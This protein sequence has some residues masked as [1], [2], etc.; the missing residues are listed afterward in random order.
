MPAL[1][2]GV[3]ETFGWRTT[4]LHDKSLH[5]GSDNDMEGLGVLEEADLVVLYLRFRQWPQED[6][7][8][9]MR[10]VDGGGALVGFR[11]ST[12]A[13]RYEVGDPRIGFNDFGAEV[14][15]A[16]WIRHYGHGAS[17]DARVVGRGRD[18]G[19]LDGVVD[20]FHVRSWT[21]HVRPDYP[22]EDAR[23]LVTG[24]PVL[25]GREAG[26]ETVNPIAWTR[27]SPGGGRVFMTTM[28]H[29]EDFRVEAFRRLVGNGMHWAAGLAVPEVGLDDFPEVIHPDDLEADGPGDEPWLRMDY[30]PAIAT[31]VGIG[32]GVPPVSKGIALPLRSPEGEDTDLWAVFDTDLCAWRCAWRGELALRGIVYD[33]PHGTYPQIDGEILFQTP[34]VSGV[35]V[36]GDALGVFRDPR[37]EAWGPVPSE[38]CRWH[39]LHFDGRDVIFEYTGHGDRERVFERVWAEEQDGRWVFVREV[40]RKSV[41]AGSN[42]AE[43][44]FQVVVLGPQDPGL[45]RPEVTLVARGHGEFRGDLLA[46]FLPREERVLISI[47]GPDGAA[48]MPAKP[49]PRTLE[50]ALQS[51]RPRWGGPW[52]AEGLV[53]M[54]EDG[55]SGA[56]RF[57]ISGSQNGSTHT[58]TTAPAGTL[59]LMLE[60][61]SVEQGAASEAVILQRGAAPLVDPFESLKPFARRGLWLADRGNGT[62]ERNELSGEDDLRLDGVTWRRGVRGRSLD[63]DG[64]AAAWVEGQDL[65]FAEQDIT[66]AAWVHTTRDG[67]VFAMA[68]DATESWAPDGVTLFLREGRLAFDV[69]WVGVVTGGPDIRDGAWH[70]VAA[71]W[72]HRDG[73]VRLFL[74]GRYVQGGSLALE[75]HPGRRGFLPRWGWT[76][77]DFP[78]ES[79]FSGYMDG[80]A[81]LGQ[82]LDDELIDDLAAASGEEIVEATL[83]RWRGESDAVPTLRLRRSAEQDVVILGPHAVPT[84]AE[85]MGFSV[86]RQFGLRSVVLAWARNFESGPETRDAFRIDRLSWPGENPHGAWMRFGAMDLA[87]SANGRIESA[88]LTTWSG[89]LWRVDGLDE[90]L[91][92]L[93]WTRVATG[94][95]QPFGVLHRER[96]GGRTET[97][98]LGRDQITRVHDRNGDGEADFLEA[99]SNLNRNSEHF[100]EPASGLLEGPDGGLMYIKAARHAKHGLHSHHGTVQRV[101]ADGSRT[102]AIA[103]GFRAPIGLRLLPDGT[104]LGSDQEGHWTPANR[105]NLIRPSPDEPRFYGNGWAANPEAEP[106][107]SAPRIQRGGEAVHPAWPSSIQPEAPLCWIHPEVD[108]SPSSQVLA[109]H[110]AWGPLEGSIL[111]LSYGTGEV[112]LVLRDEFDGPNGRVTA[113]GGVV[114]LGI[115]LPTGLLD[116]M[117]HPTTGDLYVCGLFGWS[118][119]R[120]EPGG[121]YRVRPQWNGGATSL[122]VPHQVRAGETGLTLTF[123]EPLD[124]ESAHDIENWDA[125]AWNYRRS[126]DYGSATYTLDGGGQGR[127]QLEVTQVSVSPNPRIVHVTIADL[128]PCD[129]LDLHWSILDARGRALEHSAHLTLHA[130]RKTP[131]SGAP[132]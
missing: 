77:R 90:T 88:L 7:D 24:R 95:N 96:P 131:D 114:K 64:T 126:A 91:E 52:E 103:R 42:A 79:R 107:G 129:Q 87:P 62:H 98:V 17:T 35:S 18:D 74:D 85:G 89:D 130:Q 29:P 119:D 27:R 46:C 38:V 57:E 72:R 127:T 80:L 108:R 65:D 92:S 21:Y 45:V 132:R 40:T 70:H 31:A 43:P 97:L 10:Y 101:S 3:E 120:T 116:G 54:R 36:Q 123:M 56:L 51:R 104:L 69:G 1:A 67:T 124:M 99:F 60:E 61:E 14:L 25:P 59:G 4:V 81:L 13:F 110:P 115:Q 82:A 41:S 37:E 83:V 30:G 58:I 111:G 33:G 105:I 106:L 20:D 16:P 118:S 44:E 28:G 11:T 86:H 23:I 26:D 32:D 63:F 5:A 6:L 71:T 112:Y 117:I 15:G 128:R 94:F 102:E 93:R 8:A 78:S 2:L 48:P 121:F 109:N 73:D 53:G 9:L 12:H 66:V 68:P 122:N 49:H 125:T 50:D 55:G 76:N 113:L 22:T 84:G 47:G 75:G 34:P 100:H 39:G 19:I